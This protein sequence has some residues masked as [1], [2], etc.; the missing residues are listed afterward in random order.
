MADLDGLEPTAEGF[1]E[2]AFDQPLEPPLEPLESH[3]QGSVSVPPFTS[4]AASADARAQHVHGVPARGHWYA[5]TPGRVA[6]LADAQASGACVRKDVG[7]QVPPR[8]LT[9]QLT[10]FSLTDTL[11]RSPLCSRVE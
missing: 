8:P 3:W 1:V 10:D 4:R 7:V 5:A 6:E 2:G 9:H 11:P